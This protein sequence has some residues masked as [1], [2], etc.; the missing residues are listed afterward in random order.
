MKVLAIIPAR[1][2]DSFDAGAGGP[3]KKICIPCGK[4]PALETEEGL[5]VALERKILVVLTENAHF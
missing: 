4:C 3:S 5:V 1:M 2:D